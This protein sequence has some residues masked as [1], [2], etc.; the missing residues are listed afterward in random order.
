MLQGIFWS[1]LKET[2]KGNHQF[3]A[4][5]LGDLCWKDVDSQ[6]LI[7]LLR[8]RRRLLEALEVPDT[9]IK[10]TGQ[11][12]SRLERFLLSHRQLI[13]VP[14]K[15]QFG[16][17]T[18][19]ALGL[20]LFNGQSIHV[21][22]L[23]DLLEQCS[24]LGLETL[25]PVT[26]GK[27]LK[28]LEK[29]NG[30]KERLRDKE[31]TLKT[32]FEGTPAL[33]KVRETVPMV[34]P[35]NKRW[36]HAQVIGRTG[37]GKTRAV[38]G[39]IAHNLEIC[40]RG[41]G[42]FCVMESNGDLFRWVSHLSQLDPEHPESLANQVIMIDVTDLD[43]LAQMNLFDL[44]FDGIRDHSKV[45]REKIFSM[46]LE[47]YEYM[48]TA[49][50]GLE[51][52]PY[53]KNI[54]CFGTQIIF[55][56]KGNLSTFLQLMRSE[57]GDFF[58]AYENLDPYARKF[59]ED[60]F[61]RKEY[62]ATRDRVAVR[63][64]AVLSNS[65]FAKMLDA[66]TNTIDF[67]EIVCEGK[68]LL[69]NTSKEMLQGTRS[70]ALGKFILANLML[71][72]FRM[73]GVPE[74]KRK[75]FTVYL[76]ECHDLF[77]SGGGQGAN[78]LP[79]MLSQ[80]RKYKVGL[81]LIHQSLHQLK[82]ESGLFPSVMACTATKI[83]GKVSAADAEDFSKEL[84]CDKNI[85]QRLK[86]I[87]FKSSEFVCYIGETTE[88]PCVVQMSLSDINQISLMDENGFQRLRE[89]CRAKQASQILENPQSTEDPPKNF[90]KPIF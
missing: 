1:E 5:V 57:E 65:T 2:F 83:I 72:G 25:M 48:F 79:M 8:L 62:A 22:D 86:K 44:N 11:L 80:M 34:L 82:Q 7:S 12:I 3:K 89:V 90:E 45:E 76:D 81:V 74:K 49:L 36:E 21:H 87:D 54:F 73:A 20:S 78:I 37:W 10:E 31:L 39:L 58:H 50:L 85:F 53:M 75:G 70:S 64:W 69:V 71:A 40:R 17:F 67:F 61:Y 56:V 63:L 52:S 4:W 88:T 84:G 43:H 28:N 59:F 15:R 26:H 6:D 42:G 32:F 46:V 51:L 55:A 9:Y 30:R 13:K 33:K 35:Y 19:Q 18:F 38:Q 29:L 66:P 27:L 47:I 41:L 14:S 60:E 68:I 77:S 16:D 23:E 24:G